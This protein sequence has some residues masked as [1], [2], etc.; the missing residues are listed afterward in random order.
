ML[1]YPDSLR[2]MKTEFIPKFKKRKYGHIVNCKEMLRKMKRC[3]KYRPSKELK[4]LSSKFLAIVKQ[5]KRWQKTNV[6][7]GERK[8]AENPGEKYKKVKMSVSSNIN[9]YS[10]ISRLLSIWELPKHRSW[11]LRPETAAFPMKQTHARSRQLEEWFL[12]DEVLRI[13][14][15]HQGNSAGSGRYKSA[16]H[17]NPL[18][19]FW[20]YYSYC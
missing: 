12:S 8:E 9:L 3:V 18:P 6:W 11:S 5:V 13:F 20:H 17:I 15:Y 7:K 2:K 4:V 16:Q 14:P 19:H 1:R 10:T